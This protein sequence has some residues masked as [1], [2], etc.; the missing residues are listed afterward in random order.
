MSRFA[1]TAS[2]RTSAGKAVMPESDLAPEAFPELY[3]TEDS[4]FIAPI[5][6]IADQLEAVQ[7][8]L[9]KTNGRFAASIEE[10]ALRAQKAF[11]SL[12]DEYEAELEQARRTL[13]PP[14]VDGDGPVGTVPRARLVRWCALATR[15]R[16]KAFEKRLVARMEQLFPNAHVACAEFVGCVEQVYRE[17]RFVSAAVSSF[18]NLNKTVHRFLVLLWALVLAVC[19]V[20]LVDWGASFDDWIVPISSTFLSFAVLLGWLPYETIAGIAYV[21]ASRPYDIGDRIVITGAGSSGDGCEV[22]T[23][24]HIGLLSTRVISLSGEE[25]TIQNFVTRKLSV[26]NLQRSRAPVISIKLQVP[27][28]MPGAQITQLIDS[29]HAYVGSAPHDWTRVESSVIS[30]PDYV[31]GVIDVLAFVRS[32]HPPVRDDLVMLAKSRLFMFVHVYMQSA[33]LEYVTPSQ[34][35]SATLVPAPPR[36]RAAT[37]A[38]DEAASPR[39]RECVT[40]AA[41][42]S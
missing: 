33:G 3:T 10:A 19:A 38:P 35:L 21:L 6:N 29:V 11:A 41:V 42:P 30:K 13:L 32:A 23:V 2:S 12:R 34:E 9:T 18:E 40:A 1:H 28:R 7:T 8:A 25:H 24:S 36:R 37:D 20:F 31:T 26:I 22:F 4:A 27:A 5:A 16:S 14:P 15:R 17:Q 39:D